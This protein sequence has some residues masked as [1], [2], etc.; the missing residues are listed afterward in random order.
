M[1]KFGLR[2]VPLSVEL[3]YNEIE[4]FVNLYNMKFGNSNFELLCYGKVENMLI[5]GNVLNIDEDTFNY[6]L[7]DFQKRSFDVYFDGNNTHIYNYEEKN[8]DIFDKKIVKRLDFYR[9]DQSTTE[10]IIRKF[11]KI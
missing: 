3:D 4:E 10:N 9:E 1:K 2:N 5:K 8:I 7:I 6:K 11:L